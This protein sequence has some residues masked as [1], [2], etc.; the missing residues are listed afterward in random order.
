MVQGEE[1]TSCPPHLTYC[2]T[3][4]HAQ[5]PDEITRVQGDEGLVASRDVLCMVDSGGYTILNITNILNTLRN[6]DSSQLQLERL[7]SS[8][9]HGTNDTASTEELA[10]FRFGFPDLDFAVPSERVVAGSAIFVGTNQF[11]LPLPGTH[12][13]LNSQTE[14]AGESRI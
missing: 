4:I 3:S 11:T 12:L 8:Q 5:I 6:P 2:D 14:N 13:L 10:A 1:S 9:T 7:Y